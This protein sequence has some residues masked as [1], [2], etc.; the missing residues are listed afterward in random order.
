M[1]NYAEELAY[2]YFRFNG[3]FVVDD[4]V[5][6]RGGEQNVYNLNQHQAGAHSE[7]DILGI[8]PSFVREDIG[9]PPHHCPIF[10]NIAPIDNITVG[11]ICEIKAGDHDQPNA[12]NLWYQI[13]RLGLFDNVEPSH[14]ALL[15]N[16]SY[17][18][19]NQTNM[20][21]KIL[22]KNRPDQVAGWHV[23]TIDQI[24]TFIRER[25]LMFEEKAGGWVMFNSSLM[26]F[27]L[28]HQ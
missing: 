9:F 21:I 8:R 11:L 2:W 10:A 16:P 5:I 18:D 14:E 23:I 13:R 17:M 4:F 20:I 6:H 22:I 26:Q 1:K 24:I 19:D 15:Q 12:N 3:F 27:L 28:K 25:F 7:T